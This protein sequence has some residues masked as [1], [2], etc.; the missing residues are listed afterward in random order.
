MVCLGFERRAEGHEGWKAQMNPLSHYIRPLDVSDPTNGRRGRG[1]SVEGRR[2]LV[3]RR[4]DRRL[5]RLLHLGRLL[6]RRSNP[7]ISVSNT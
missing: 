6:L 1:Q 5:P 2:I 3:V 4:Q 7:T